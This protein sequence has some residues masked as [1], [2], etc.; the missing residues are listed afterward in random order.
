MR[1]KKQF[2]TNGG[3]RSPNVY[4]SVEVF[5][6]S[7]SVTSPNSV[8]SRSFFYVIDHTGQRKWDAAPR[9]AELL[10]APMVNRTIGDKRG[11]YFRED[12]FSDIMIRIAKHTGVTHS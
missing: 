8:L 11:D 12:N 6:K 10:F 5:E 4:E 7:S 2:S 1:T 3:F 9:E